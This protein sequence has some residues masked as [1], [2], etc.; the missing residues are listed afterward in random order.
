MNKMLRSPLFL[1]IARFIGGLGASNIGS[2]QA[3]VKAT[4]HTSWQRTCKS[5]TR[6][7]LVPRLLGT[8]TIRPL[9]EVHQTSLLVVKYKHHIL[10]PEDQ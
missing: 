2:A 9:A 7:R 4:K 3:V 1:L 6:Q 5:N 8:E 10:F